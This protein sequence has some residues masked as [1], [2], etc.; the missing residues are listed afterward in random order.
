MS[1]TAGTRAAP[2]PGRYTSPTRLTPS[3]AGIVT[4]ESFVIPAACAGAAASRVA[5][6]NASV[7]I[8]RPRRLDLMEGPDSLRYR[9]RPDSNRTPVGRAAYGS[10]AGPRARRPVFVFTRQVSDRS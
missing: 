3:L 4:S 1:T 6:A 5:A 7:A 10:A 9:R 8:A 2:L